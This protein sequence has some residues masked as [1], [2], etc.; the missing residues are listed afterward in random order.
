MSKILLSMWFIV[1]IVI[2]ETGQLTMSTSGDP[3]LRMVNGAGHNLI[4][5]PVCHRGENMRCL[6]WLPG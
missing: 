4:W 2:K 5:M 6:I 3:G 1:C